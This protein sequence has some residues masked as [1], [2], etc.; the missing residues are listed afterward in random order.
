MTCHP[1]DGGCQGT[2]ILLLTLSAPATVAVGK[3]GQ[4]DFETGRFAYVGSAFGPGGLAGRLGRYIE[5]P[6]RRHWHI[7]YLLEHAEGTGALVSSRAERFEC[8]W[9]AWLESRAERT[10]DGFGS[11]DC[12][13]RG[14]LFFLGD[15]CRAQRT[16][17]ASIRTLLTTLVASGEIVKVRR[18]S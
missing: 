16:I 11:S 8:R 1:L 10:V 15:E 4:L 6:R 13:C 5:G 9:A 3:L 7:D 14:H 2:Y 17:T 18:G 12:R